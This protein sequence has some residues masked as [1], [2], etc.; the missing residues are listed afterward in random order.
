L[1]SQL[2]AFATFVESKGVELGDLCSAD[3]GLA[4]VTLAEAALKG[5]VYV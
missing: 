5:D 2:D 4:V 1:R 3:D